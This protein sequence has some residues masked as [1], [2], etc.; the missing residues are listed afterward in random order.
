MLATIAVGLE[1]AKALGLKEKYPFLALLPVS[2]PG[3]MYQCSDLRR[4]IC[5]DATDG[6]MYHVCFAKTD[7]AIHLTPMGNGGRVNILQWWDEFSR[8]LTTQC[9]SPHPIFGKDHPGVHAVD[10]Y[11][12]TSPLMVACETH[13]IRVEASTVHYAHPSYGWTYSIRLKVVD[14]TKI[15]GYAQSD[16]GGSSSSDSDSSSGSSHSKQETFFGAQL[17]MR[18]W[19]IKNASTGQVRNVDGPG[20]IGKFPILHDKGYIDVES[21]GDDSFIQ[22]QAQDGWF[23]YQS[24][25]GNLSNGSTFGGRLTFVVNRS[26]TN[27]TGNLNAVRFDVVV[28]TFVLK[29]QEYYY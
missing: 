13:G 20:V 12:R 16:G 8:R 15:P 29:K 3:L 14:I 18:H 19:V 2:F 6:N 9:Y 7:D 11:P 26:G 10:L 5:V 22:H 1:S 23:I 21:K 27:A 25:S 17:T 24:N 28:P 4:Y